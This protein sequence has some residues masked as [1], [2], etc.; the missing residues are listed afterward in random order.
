M[1]RIQ[2]KI[3]RL[4]DYVFAQPIL[5]YRRVKYGYSYRRI[6]LGE[7]KYALVDQQ[8]YYRLNYY[9]WTTKGSGERCYAVRLECDSKRMRFVSMHREIM[10]R[11]KGL[12]VDHRNRKRLD[13]RRENLRTAT[14]S[15]NQYNKNKTKSKTSSIYKGVTYIKRTGKW[16]AQ[17]MVNRKNIALG[18]YDEEIEAAKAYDE[19]AKLY[20]KDFARL[21]FPDE[22]CNG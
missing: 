18:E 9:N 10:G 16:R 13:N 20:H 19:G 8:D 22:R 17:I 2:I 21:N 11:P 12:Q 4:I 3:P 7:G 14:N 15:Q 1:E 5:L 6:S